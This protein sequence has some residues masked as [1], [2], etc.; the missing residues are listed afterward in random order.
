MERV[1]QVNADRLRWCLDDRGVSVEAC[2]EE[3]GIS[4]PTLE[5]ALRG[6]P[7]LTVGQLRKL[8]SYFGRGMLFFLDPE[9]VMPERF[10]SPQFRTLLS[11]KA[12]L[13]PR[14]KSLIERAERQRDVYLA[15]LE[16]VGGDHI[17]QFEHPNLLG[18][19]VSDKARTCREWLGLGVKNSFD[20]Y[21]RA[22]EAKGVLVF[23]SNGYSGKWQIAKES[24]ILGFSIYDE[25][26]PLIFVRKRNSEAQQCFTLM[27]EL[28]HVLLDKRSIIDDEDDF[29]EGTGVEQRANEFAGL[30]LVPESFL[31]QI[32]D[33]TR[34]SDVSGY[35]VWLEPQRKFWGVSAEVI[36]IRL[37]NVGRLSRAQY[38]AYR[39]WSA[40][41]S[42]EEPESGGNRE[43]RHREPKHIFGLPY[44][45][46]VLDAL[47]SQKI[48]LN[49]ASTFLD[50]IKI[51]DVRQLER[52][53]AS[54]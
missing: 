36:L 16:E 14:L 29:Y 9:P 45:R 40:K 48:T 53:C 31:S 43:W 1:D 21:R 15:L 27:H 44:V 10:R 11:Q 24:P 25:R 41:K 35:D 33:S 47:G 2:A 54:V 34:P 6:E 38:Q 37:L 8:A 49:R 30:V 46:V 22:I 7:A 52:H 5:K 23:R 12:E 4:L 26:C 19:T 51:K 39:T 17:A 18:R 13:S 28:A 3:V 42:A 20:T 32:N 50:G